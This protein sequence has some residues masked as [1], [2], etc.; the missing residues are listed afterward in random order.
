MNIIS[1]TMSDQLRLLKYKINS[2]RS[3]RYI[4][5]VT[6]KR[7]Y[8][9]NNRHINWDNPQTYTE[10][11]NFSKVYCSSE[12]KT[13]LT[14]KV[15]AREWVSQRVGKQY[16]VPIIGV[17]D[18]FSEI[19]LPEMP[20]CFVLKCNHDSGSTTIIEDK[21]KLTRYDISRLKYKYDHF[22]LKRNYGYRYFEMQYVD[23]KPKVL[24]E[25]C[26]GNDIK[27]Y[28]F[29]CFDGTPYYCWVDIDRFADHKRNIYDLDWKLQPFNQMTYGNYDGFIEKPKHFDEMIEIV[30]NLCVGFDHVRVDLF[31]CNG[32][33]YFGEMTFTNGS[34]F[35]IITPPEWDAKLGGLWDL[36]LNGRR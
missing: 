32:R 11:L 31:Y 34:G 7:Y 6:D 8:L 35:E 4:E 16:L 30:K 28:K 23:I 9:K 25:Q 22:Y 3:T 14:D 19:N 20:N 10:K 36:D 29:L 17:F 33:V 21:N 27:D 18:S 26:L 2:T 1:D 24:V 12:V 13:R 5:R 15:L